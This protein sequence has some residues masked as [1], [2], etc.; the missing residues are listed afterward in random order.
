[1]AMLQT[2]RYLKTPNIRRLS[3]NVASDAVVSDVGEGDCIFS[4]GIAYSRCIEDE[5]LMRI[6]RVGQRKGKKQISVCLM[7]EAEADSP[8]SYSSCSR[9]S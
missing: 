8:L 2:Y 4:Y 5:G 3:L 6:G 7:V 1:M 9:A